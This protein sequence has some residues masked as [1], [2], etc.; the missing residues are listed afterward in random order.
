MPGAW[1]GALEVATSNVREIHIGSRAQRLDV[2][3]EIGRSPRGA[4]YHQREIRELPGGKHGRVARQNPLD[5]R[6]A[7]SRQADDE[8]RLGGIVRRRRL[9]AELPRAHV[10]NCFEE[11]EIL[12]NGVSEQSALASLAAFEM[13]ER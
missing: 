6:G 11:R 4:F 9:R 7:R 3:H 1:P 13:L 12:F 2:E 10:A 8:N 5:Q